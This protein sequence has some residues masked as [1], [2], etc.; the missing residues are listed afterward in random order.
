MWQDYLLPPRQQAYVQEPT[1]AGRVQ[2]AIK[3]ASKGMFWLKGGRTADLWLAAFTRTGHK[4]EKCW[5]IGMEMMSNPGEDDLISRTYHGF[6]GM[7]WQEAE[8]SWFE[9]YCDR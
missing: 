5:S 8:R 4:D 3:K 1:Q 9:H 2:L 6:G 7:A